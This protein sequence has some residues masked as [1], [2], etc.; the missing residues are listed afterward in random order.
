MASP[1]QVKQYI[2]HWFQLGKRVWLSS[3][4]EFKL[5]QTV[6]VGNRYSA[7]FETCWQQIISLD[8][9]D[10]YLEGTEQTI[11]ELLSPAWE[12]SDCSRCDMPIPVKNMGISPTTCPCHDLHSWPNL[13]LPIPRSPVDSQQHLQEIQERLRQN[14]GRLQDN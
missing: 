9:G 1:Q 10:C 13:E 3:G 2:A 12:M 14:L 6:L 8:S 4:Q 11:E 7:E 5:P